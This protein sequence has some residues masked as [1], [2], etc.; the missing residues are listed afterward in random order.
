[1]SIENS[2]NSSS[3][4]WALFGQVAVEMKFIDELRLND[5][6]C[7]R[8]AEENSAQAPRALAAILF[9]KEWMSSAQI[10]QVLNAVLKRSR[11]EEADLADA[12]NWPTFGRP[13]P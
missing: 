2:K 1:M 7:I 6:L 8:S 4:Y 3:R 11:M 13:P 12:K 10:D 9:D 5:A